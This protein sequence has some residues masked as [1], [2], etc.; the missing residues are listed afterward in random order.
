M[1]IPEAALRVVGTERIPSI[2]QGMGGFEDSMVDQ[3][4][5]RMRQVP[6]LSG[7]LGDGEAR[8][9]RA[10]PSL[11]VAVL[12]SLPADY[13]WSTSRRGLIASSLRP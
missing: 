4:V 3:A 6:H 1:A 13:S 2:T 8:G 11:G 9:K 5:G 7:D 10:V 12:I